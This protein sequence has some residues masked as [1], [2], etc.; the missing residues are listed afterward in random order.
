MY[1]PSRPEK[2]VPSRAMGSRPSL[3]GPTPL[4]ARL[5][6]QF[7]VRTQRVLAGLSILEYPSMRYPA[8]RSPPQSEKIQS[9]SQIPH[10]TSLHVLGLSMEFSPASSPI[11][12]F[13]L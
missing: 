12:F 10:N 9:T 13:R 4:L 5:H 11:R 6:Y 7:A 1:G 3:I 8:Q 2:Q